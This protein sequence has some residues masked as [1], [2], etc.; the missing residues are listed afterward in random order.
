VRELL[1]HCKCPAYGV[2][3]PDIG[4]EGHVEEE[5]GECESVSE[6]DNE[7]TKSPYT[8]LVFANDSC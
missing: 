3:L 8:N 6:E 4:W 1:R 2:A 7:E 5:G